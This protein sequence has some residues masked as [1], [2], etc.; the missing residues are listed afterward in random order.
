MAA[1]EPDALGCCAQED[2]SLAAALI[3][4]PYLLIV[5][6]EIVVRD[7]QLLAQASTSTPGP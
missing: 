3:Q 2:R 1:Q 6:R 4:H 5:G 7:V